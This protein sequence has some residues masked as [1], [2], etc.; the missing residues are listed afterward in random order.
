MITNIPYIKFIKVKFYFAAPT[1]QSRKIEF[2]I[3]IIATAPSHDWKK[4]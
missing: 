3:P 2:I 1:N 4:N